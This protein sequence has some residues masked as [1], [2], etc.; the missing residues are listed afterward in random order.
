MLVVEAK[1][2]MAPRMVLRRD[3]CSPASRMAPT[4]AMAEMALVER[5][6]RRVQQARHAADDHQT[7]EGRQHQ[8]EQAAQEIKL[9]RGGILSETGRCGGIDWVIGWVIRRLE[10]GDWRLGDLFGD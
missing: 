8:H 6:E 4:T 7:N 1:T 5:H 9:H 10:I 2:A 3:S